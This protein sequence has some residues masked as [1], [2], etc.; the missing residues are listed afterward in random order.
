M[1]G[2]I[3]ITTNLC[4]GMKYI[5]QHK[6]STFEF[7]KYI[8]SGTVLANVLKKYGADNFK[9]ELLESVNNV[10]TV[11]DTQEGLNKSEIYY[12]EYY[13][14][15]ESSDYYNI[16]RG[17]Q[18]GDCYSCIS[19]EEKDIHDAKI[20]AASLNWW[21]S[22]DKDELDKRYA[23]WIKSYQDHTPEE[24]E[25][26]RKVNSEAQLAYNASLTEEQKE[27]RR[28]ASKEVQ[29]RRVNNPEVERIRK[30]KENATKS[31]WTAEQREAYRDKQHKMQSG[32]RYYTNGVDTIKC[33][34]EDAPEEYYPG[35]AHRNNYRYT[36]YYEGMTFLGVGRLVEYLRN[37]GYS[38]A[39]PD[40]II[41]LGKNDFVRPPR[42]LES[43]VGK[44]VLE[45][46]K[47]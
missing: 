10:P 39:H 36:C 6:S 13:N 23:N 28:A 38:K 24:L 22:A 19:Q 33:F 11:C 9:C 14:C 43:L 4:N 37:I 18:E 16:A 34:P 7:T 42:G 12:I 45:D 21:N 3:Y 41:K 5:G 40:A 17:G 47:R 27:R 31:A 8:G 15:V 20:L 32:R 26:R 35:G 1:Y 46:A 30:E 44:I 29:Q 25:N 2:Y